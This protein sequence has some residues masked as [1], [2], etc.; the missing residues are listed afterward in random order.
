MRVAPAETLPPLAQKTWRVGT[1]VYD[2]RQLFSVFF[3]MLWGDFVLNIMDNG[4]G[5]NVALIQLNKYGASKTA[6]GLLTGSVPEFLSIFMVAIISTWSDR[7]RG[8]M[9]RRMPFMFWS[10]PPIAICL[11]AMGFSP[12]LATWMQRHVPG[13]MAGLSVSA[14]TITLFSIFYIGY[15]FGDLFPQSVYYYL[16][17]DAIPHEVMGTFVSLFRIVA[18]AG[19]LLF[20][21]FLLKHCEDN[22]ALICMI[23]A[24]AYLL[25]FVLMCLRVKEGEYPP[26]EPPPPGTPVERAMRTIR[27]YIKECYSLSFYWKYFLFTFCFMCGFRP[28]NNFLLLYGK[29]TLKMPLESYGRWTALASLVQIV[30][31]FAAGPVIDRVHPIRAGLFGYVVMC[32]TAVLSYCFISGPTSFGLWVVATFA[33]IAIYQSATG[34]LNPRIL[35]KEQYGQFCSANAM[36]WH[37]G[38]MVLTPILGFL[39]DTFGNAMMFVWF[40]SFSAVGIVAMFLVYRDWKAMGGERGYRPPL[41]EQ[42]SARGFAAESG[43]P[44]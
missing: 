13:L 1:L 33:A 38:L 3:W 5:S 42:N 32:A 18:T 11:A 8:P 34:A 16:W 10:A 41:I 15:R 43:E 35:P 28:F 6:I 23:C 39:L 44:V 26:P 30:A 36:I 14:M 17:T 9:G 40:F 29:E 4:V 22:P 37:L 21:F 20:Q 7:H 12:Q 31:L 25:V 27:R 2:R 24:V 19:T